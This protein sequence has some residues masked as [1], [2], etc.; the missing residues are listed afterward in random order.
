MI[1]VALRNRPF[2]RIWCAATV[3]GIGSNMTFLALP[4]LALDLTG[5]SAAYATVFLGTSA[6][7]LLSVLFGGAFAD[8]YDRRNLVLVGDLVGMV[9]VGLLSVSVFFGAWGPIPL[10]AMLIT[11]TGGL[12]HVAGPAMTRDL[13]PEDLRQSS[14]AVSSF[15]HGL[16]TL[17][18]PLLGVALYEASGMQ[19]VLAL[20]A[21][22]YIC[23]LALIAG[24]R[25]PATKPRR[26]AI[27]PGAAAAAAAVIRDI[28]FAF[29][30]VRRDAF[31][32]P[33]TMASF[34]FGAAHA[35][36][37]ALLLPWVVRVL[38]APP[39]VYALYVCAIG[40]AIL[41]GSSVLGR[42]GDRIVPQ[43][44]MYAAATVTILA[45]VGFA[46][47]RSVPVFL[48]CAALLG[49]GNALMYV[50][51][52][53]IRQARMSSQIQGRTLALNQVAFQAPQIPMLAIAA[54][55]MGAVSLQAIAI[56]MACLYVAASLL[57]IKAATAVRTPAEPHR[58]AAV[59]G[60]GPDPNSSLPTHERV[61]SS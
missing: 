5:S 43:H 21:A 24:L 7:V 12:F 15:G 61:H 29:R 50:P 18:A 51:A 38:D 45:G 41:L 59:L 6:G 55:V 58:G 39:S 11:F 35:L 1:P 8:R 2:A 9:L 28:R 47:S 56:V 19:V 37:S 14:N 42:I 53:T 25:H 30:V 22:T 34:T 20:D 40:A 31:F 48:G 27:A 33:H 44:L 60:A 26:S 32:R 52:A 46:A 13:V 16:S 54:L 57:D 23:S 36:L 49:L 4:Y 10:I 3:S 17:G